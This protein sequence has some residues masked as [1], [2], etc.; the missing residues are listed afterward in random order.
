MK[1]YST[2]VSLS[3]RLELKGIQPDFFTLNILMNCFCHMGQINFGFSV[4]AKILKRGY[5]PHTITFTTLIK[6]LCLKGQVNKALHFHDKLLAQGIKF[7]QVSYGTLINGVCKIGDTR[8][9]IKLVR[10]IDG[11]LTKPNVEMYNTII[12]ALCKYQLVSE[13]YGLFSEMTAKGISANVVIATKAAG[14]RTQDKG[15]LRK[16]GPKGLLGDQPN[17]KITF[18]FSITS[19]C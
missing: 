6:G 2:A 9:A 7:D 16:A 18:S 1:H 11:R 12:D 10:K 3:H 8:G 19:S 15:H 17:I 5:Q 4:L 13:A 14:H